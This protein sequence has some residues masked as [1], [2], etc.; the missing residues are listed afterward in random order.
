MTEPP[1]ELVLRAFGLRAAPQHL[2]GGLTKSAWRV[3]D[4]VVKPVQEPNPGE[5]EWVADM[6]DALAEDG[7]RVAKPLRS[8]DG[9]WTVDGWTAWQWLDGEHVQHTWR[10]VTT[11][12]RALHTAIRAFAAEKP[13]WMDARSHRWAQSERTVWHG[14]PLPSQANYDVPEWRLYERAVALGPPLTED[15]RRAAQVVHGDVAGNVLALSD[16]FGFIDFSPGWR[17]PVSVDAQIVVEGVAWF[18][19]DEALLAEVDP[20]DVARAC[21]FRLLCGFQFI[22]LG[23]EFDPDEVA[24]FARVLDAVGA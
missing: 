1:P 24:R 22:T 13:A 9:A 8:V 23:V 15:A 21:A 2:P 20:A 4:A 3:G 17:P 12:A 18:G 7:F 5:G 6:L 16:G 11:A 10:E 14:A 19:G